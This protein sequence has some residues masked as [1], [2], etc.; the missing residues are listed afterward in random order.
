M[1]HAILD[2]LRPR[3]VEPGLPD[4]LAF[5]EALAD[6]VALLSVFT[7]PGV[8]VTYLLRRTPAAGS[9]S[10][11]AGRRLAPGREHA[12][13]RLARRRDYLTRSPLFGLAE[14]LGRA[15]ESRAGRDREP[16]RRCGARW[17]SRR[18]RR[19]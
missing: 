19:G 4:Q 7:L 13:A 5:H 18:P 1:T 14:Q 2:G 16:R 17:R 6:L 3:Y 11:A 15:R 10:T 12:A 8:V 9:G